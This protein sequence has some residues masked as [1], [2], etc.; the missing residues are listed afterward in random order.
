[1]KKVIGI[2]SEGPT[3]YL[4]LK[5]V[6]D[7]ITGEENRYLPLQPEPDMLGRYGNGWKGVWRWCKETGSIGMLMQEVQPNIDAIVIQMDGD[8][9]RKEKEVHCL[10]ETIV[11]EDKGKVFPL[12]CE[13]VADRK[14]PV[15]LP[16]KRHANGIR[17]MMD[18]GKS[19]LEAEFENEDMARIAIII[20]CDSTDTWV[21][22]AYD[23][24]DDVELFED[25]WDRI[26]AKGKYYHGIR[27]RGN[28]KNT[29][30]YKL[31]S[32][33]V[34]ECWNI[35]TEKCKSAVTLEEEI[36]RILM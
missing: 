29:N 1:M 15:E 2:V 4:V 32:M 31:F 10:C 11:C 27:V 26:I 20:P 34:A 25:P 13:N 23:E 6:I 36:K 5:A 3:D 24:M 30:T 9:V 35:V 19:V 17:G 12:Y 7:K 33:R 14:C 8:V 28:K 22:A 18:H 16:C 21:V